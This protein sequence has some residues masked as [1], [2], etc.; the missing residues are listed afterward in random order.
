MRIILQ[1]LSWKPEAR[2][3]RAFEA[4]E[5]L[6][7]IAAAR[8]ADIVA[9]VP[10][11]AAAGAP[12][13]L[14][15][16]G[17]A[18]PSTPIGTAAFAMRG[19]ERLARSLA[20]DVLYSLE[21]SAPWRSP[22]PVVATAEM[23][24][25]AGRGASRWKNAL[26]RAGLAGASAVLLADDLPPRP[27]LPNVRRV[28]PIV[29]S[30]FR[31]PGRA[32]RGGGTGA[33]RDSVL[34]W[35]EDDVGWKR[36]LAAWTWVDASLGDSVRL[37]LLAPGEH[38]AQRVSAEARHLGIHESVET[39]VPNGLRAVA[40][41]HLRARV[42]LHAGGFTTVQIFRW[43]LASGIPVAAESSPEADSIIGPAAYLVRPSDTRALGAAALTLLVE[44]SVAERLRELGLRRTQ[45]YDPES[46]GL[47]RRLDILQEAARRSV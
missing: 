25:A 11:A 1:A 36:M 38:I 27:D 7:T 34:G 41:L 23:A 31:P 8:R 14:A 47:S 9:L 26:R 5:F 43:A 40:D 17:V 13:G 45:A 18:L 19:V 33:E 16:H 12:P 15:V 10:A 22:I 44:E 46:G 6:E 37:V 2:T 35:A 30:S 32:E 24:T 29:S 42:L 20:G 39:V 4:R 21:E 28:P 3:A